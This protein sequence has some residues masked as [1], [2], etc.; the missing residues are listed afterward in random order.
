MSWY[1]HWD[2]SFDLAIGGIEL[3]FRKPNDMNQLLVRT[4]ATL[5]ADKIID[6]IATPLA[7][8]RYHVVGTR[9]FGKS[10]ILNYFAFRL[11]SELPS[12]KVLPVYTSLSG[13]A[14]DDKDLESVFFKSLLVSLF[15]VPLDIRRFQLENEFEEI[16]TQL[17]KASFEYKKQLQDFGQVSLDHV[18]TALNNQLDHLVKR[19]EKIVFLIDGLD[20]QKTET[21][22]K[23][24]RSRQE[25]LSNLITKYNLILIDAADPDW[26]EILGTKEFGGIRGVLLNLRG[27]TCDEVRLL[28]ENRL[29]RIGIYQMPFDQKALEAIVADFQGNPREILQYCTTLLHYAATEKIRTIGQGVAREVVWTDTSKAKFYKFIISDS[30]AR[31]AFEKLR[32]VF[33]NRQMMNMLSATYTQNMRHLSINLDYDKRSAIGITLSDT[34]YKRFV[35]I[36][37]T[38]GCFK[39]KTQNYVE[40][41]DDVKKLYDFVSEMGESLVALPV[42]LRTLESKIVENTQT[43][44]EDISIKEEISKVFEQHPNKWMNYSQCKQILLENPRTKDS[45][46]EHFKEKSDEK[47]TITIPLMVHDLLLEAKLMQDEESS[48]FRWRPSLIDS[49]TADFFKSKCILDLIE[50]AKRTALEGDMIKVALLCDKLVS[51]SLAK[52][53]RLFGDRI[54]ANNIYEFLANMRVEILKPVTLTSFMQNLKEPITNI[55]EANVCIQTAILYARRFFTK[56]H[57]LSS[58]EPKTKELLNQLQKCKT[59][60]SKITERKH[61]NEF[62]LPI[63]MQNYGR[64]LECMSAIKLGDGIL[65]KIPPE[66][67]SLI[68]NGQIIQVELYRCPMCK[69]QTAS[70]MAKSE[71]GINYCVDCKV[72]CNHVG[73]AF[74]LGKEAYQA[75][76]VWM[77]EYARKMLEVFPVRYVE[78]GLMLKP[79]GT[80]AITSPEEVDIVF[81]FNGKLIAVE[82]TEKVIVNNKKNDVLNIVQKI[83]SLGL[84]NSIILLYRQVNNTHAFNSEIKKYEKT[85]IPIL[86]GNPS[87]IRLSFL[88]AFQL[89]EEIKADMENSSEDTRYPRARFFEDK[90]LRI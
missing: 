59:G 74:I 4:E 76:N 44:E 10:T 14:T 34:D 12:K 55:D 90:I 77:E 17:S 38:R 47:I 29:T 62:L 35:D 65:E 50:S 19:F 22:L 8:A 32:T 69:K 13:T 15:D 27:W 25:Y 66:L 11:F 57:Q 53:I 89:I 40:L 42:V 68:R 2:S 88:K 82:C 80:E 67:T 41:D 46:S 24:L 52:L 31:Y 36:L 51:D 20:K 18:S 43:Q 78:T 73:R 39:I 81:A 56:I 61:F 48:E 16:S 9:G 84:F 30:G 63:L 1:I 83:G 54:N 23:F 87:S 72:E 37:L 33:D 3:S 26:R 21:V 49:D 5:L 64:L 45:L 79:K 75:W 58:F 28:I 71:I 6:K 86:I 85:L 60:N 70:T 7:S